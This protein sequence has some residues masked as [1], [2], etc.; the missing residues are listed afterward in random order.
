MGL[1]IGVPTCDPSIMAASVG[2]LTTDPETNI[3]VDKTED[4]WSLKT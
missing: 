1:C 3:P 4:A 2:G